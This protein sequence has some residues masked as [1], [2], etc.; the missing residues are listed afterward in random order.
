MQSPHA[1]FAERRDQRVDEAA[2]EPLPL[3]F[4]QQVDV[5][6]RGIGV[7]ERLGTA[8][9]TVGVG[10]DAVLARALRGGALR[11]GQRPTLGEPRPPL[12]L[13]PVLERSRVVR[14]DDVARNAAVIGLDDEREVWVPRHIGQHEHL[15]PQV[16]V[17]EDAGR[18]GA[19]VG[20]LQADLRQGGFVAGLKRADAGHP[21]SL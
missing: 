5:Q 19:G 4:G 1:A 11:V 20:G 10:D 6:V 16:V 17:G 13:E 8:A 9:A 3:Q 7:A 21:F 14:A 12:A 15:A 2:T 18:V